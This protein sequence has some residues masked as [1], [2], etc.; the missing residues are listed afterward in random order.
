MGLKT[1][2]KAS[3]LGFGPQGW[4]IGL[5]AEIW[6]WRWGGGGRRRRRKRRKFPCVKA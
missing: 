3:R 5:E 1:G 2:I 4:D 6:A